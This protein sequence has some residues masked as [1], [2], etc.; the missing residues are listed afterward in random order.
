MRRR[1]KRSS[2]S[3]TAP[4]CRA[5][6]ICRRS[7]ACFGVERE[8]PRRASAV[9][10]PPPP[11]VAS[12]A[13]IAPAPLP[14]FGSPPNA[15]TRAVSADSALQP[16][17]AVDSQR[18]A[19]NGRAG[20]G[21]GRGSSARSESAAPYRLERV[22]PETCFGG[23]GFGVAGNPN[24]RATIRPEARSSQNSPLRHRDRFHQARRVRTPGRR[25]KRRQAAL[26][27]CRRPPNAI[28]SKRRAA[29]RP[30]RRTP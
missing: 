10:A 8:A 7:P 26:S 11:G 1:R 2:S 21:F 27:K 9:P 5:P 13:P 23:S 19:L 4:A 29:T 15:A 30:E 6:S 3:E 22:R 20:Q 12:A 17:P 16:E 24:R 28:R 18:A 25:L 14:R